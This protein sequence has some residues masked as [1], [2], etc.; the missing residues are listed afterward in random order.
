M[1]RGRQRRFLQAK[2]KSTACGKCTRGDQLLGLVERAPAG[3][4]TPFGNRE[5]LPPPKNS[6]NKMRATKGNKTQ[7]HGGFQSGPP[8]QY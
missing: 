3:N 7:G 5:K 8:P 4:E 2:Y 1:G 6:K